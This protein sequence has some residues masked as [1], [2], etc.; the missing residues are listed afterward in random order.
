[1]LPHPRMGGSLPGMAEENEE[2]RKYYTLKPK[3]FE[4]VNRP[5]HEEPQGAIDVHAMLQQNLAADK[6]R[7]SAAPRIPP[8]SAQPV[9]S[10]TTSGDPKPP[11]LPVVK[12]KARR[13]NDY[14]NTLACAAVVFAVPAYFCRD[15]DLVLIAIGLA[16]GVFALVMAWIFFGIMDRY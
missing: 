4:R 1:M 3:S 7:S 12:Q 16:Y 11:V 10:A 14:F 15:S 5:V 6:E 9:P 13:R 8:P 2:E